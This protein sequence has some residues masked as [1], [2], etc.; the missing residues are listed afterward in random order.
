V[1]PRSQAW[2]VVNWLT[3]V[4]LYCCAESV[5]DLSN[6]G[7]ADGPE[8]NGFKAVAGSAESRAA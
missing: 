1:G 8:V 5:S 4:V 2:T 3:A 7:V 6:G